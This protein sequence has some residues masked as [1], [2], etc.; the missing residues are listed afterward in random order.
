MHWSSVWDELA[1]RFH[2]VAPDLPGLGTRDGEPLTSIEACAKWLRALLEALKVPRVWCVGN[3]FGASVACRFAR[4]FP[5]DCAGLVLVNGFQMPRSPRIL[6]WL[7]ER[8]LGH[9]IV[10]FMER[11]IA[12]STYALERGFVDL[13]RAP[14][15]LRAVLGAAAQPELDAMARILVQGDSN[16]PTRFAPLL[17]WGQDDRLPGTTARAARKL[18]ARMPGSKLVFVEK[19]G[20]MPQV[21]NPA[22][23]VEALCAFVDITR[24]KSTR[25]PTNS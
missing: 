23:F 14:E 15:E 11:K 7:G 5:D 18:H 8:R 10:R 3:S 21:E 13:S 25:R 19:T 24:D 1:K 12:Y 4:D 9:R 2:V 17:L 6:R 22:A 16:A 20:H